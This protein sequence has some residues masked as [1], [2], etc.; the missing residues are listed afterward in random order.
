MARGSVLNVLVEAPVYEVSGI[1]K[2]PQLDIVGTLA[3]EE[4]NVALFV[5]NRDLSASH[6]VDVAW[7][8]ASPKRAVSATVLTG[9]DLKAFNSFDAPTRVS[10][11][12]LEK[13]V[14]SEG[15]TK[16]QVPPRSYTVLQWNM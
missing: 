15:H 4:G 12:E 9:N 7:E 14:T 16:F 1:G 8:D 10:P 13:P 5:L 6:E 11:A 3:K 2:V